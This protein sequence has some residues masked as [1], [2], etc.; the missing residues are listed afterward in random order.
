MA[1]IYGHWDTVAT[2][3]K[4]GLSH[5]DVELWAV[6]EQ[7]G[8][9]TVLATIDPC[10]TLGEIW[11]D[12]GDEILNSLVEN[13]DPLGE[14]KSMLSYWQ[15]FNS[16]DLERSIKWEGSIG[17]YRIWPASV[18]KAFSQ[19]MLKADEIRSSKVWGT[20]LQSFAI[21]YLYEFLNC[22]DEMWLWRLLA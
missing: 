5:T 15:L 17:W 10:S 7:V 22:S 16:F 11:T 19:G 4:M 18:L 14:G 20:S 3:I 12:H 6:L 9:Q 21:A 2:L 1:A 8:L 13:K